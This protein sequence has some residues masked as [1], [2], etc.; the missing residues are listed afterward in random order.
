VAGAIVDSNTLLRAT[1]RGIDV[2]A[3]IDRFDSNTLFKKIGGSLIIT[4]N[5]GTNVSDMMLYL[6]GQ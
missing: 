6:L 2:K 4:G 1:S 3:Y 5:T